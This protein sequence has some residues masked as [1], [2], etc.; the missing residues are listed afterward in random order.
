M[1]IFSNLNSYSEICMSFD[2]TFANPIEYVDFNQIDAFCAV[3]I[4][5]RRVLIWIEFGGF[6]DFLENLNTF[7]W[8]CFVS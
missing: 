6:N 7:I 4:A 3:F 5:N 1:F 8:S 2:V